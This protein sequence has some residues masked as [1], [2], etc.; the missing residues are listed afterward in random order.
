M[1]G[2]LVGAADLLG[3]G[4][5]AR[6]GEADVERL[7]DVQQVAEDVPGRAEEA[8][9]V[10]Q[11]ADGPV[12]GEGAEERAAAGPAIEPDDQR[13]SRAGLVHVVPHRSEQLIVHAAGALG[14]I[15][16]DLLIA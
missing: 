14:P 8:G 16:I 3:R 4:A 15:P 1:S 13:D 6:V 7:V 12:L 11:D 5:V 2:A 9:L 10:L